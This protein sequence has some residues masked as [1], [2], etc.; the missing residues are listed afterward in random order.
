CFKIFDLDRDGVLNKKELI[1]MVGILC[2]VANESLKNSSRASTP[3][4][5]NESEGTEKGFDPEVILL[6]L[7]DKLITVPRNGRKPVFQLGVAGE[8]EDIVV[9]K[10]DINHESE[11]LIAN[12]LA[13]TLE[14][15]LI[16]SVETAENLVSP[17]LELVFEVCHI[18]L[19][20]RPHCKHQERDI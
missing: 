2:T 8:G 11:G 18:V 9:V 4:D 3:S 13:L 5:G 19:G 6:N 7:R 14:D 10:E 16:W 15:F 20:L 12:D 1:D 17:F